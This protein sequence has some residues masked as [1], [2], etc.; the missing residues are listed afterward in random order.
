MK[1]ALSQREISKM[2]SKRKTSITTIIMIVFLLLALSADVPK[3]SATTTETPWITPAL[4]EPFSTEPPFGNYTGC[5]DETLENALDEIDDCEGDKPLYVLVCADEEERNLIRRLTRL[6]PGHLWRE[7]ATI[8]IERGDEALVANF[9]IDIRILGFEEWITDDNITRMYDS[10]LPCLWNELIE[11]KGHYLNQWYEGEHWSDYVDAII[12]ITYQPTPDYNPQG[13]STSPYLLDQRKA[14]V[15]LRWYLHWVD[16][17]LVQH[18]ISHLYYAPDHPADQSTPCGVMANHYHYHTIIY[19]D[20]YWHVWA[21]MPCVATAYTW[22]DDCTETIQE[23]S[24]RYASKVLTISSFY[25]GTTNPSPGVYEYSYG[26][27]VKISAIRDNCY[28]RF[29]CWVL[30]GSICLYNPLTVTMTWNHDVEAYFIACSGGGGGDWPCP[31]LFVWNGND[32]VDYGVIDIHD[33][34]G[35]DMVREVSIAKQDLAVEDGKAKLQLQEGWLGLNFSESVIDQ[36]KLYAI[37]EDGKLKLCPLTT[38]VHSRLGDVREYVVASDD[39]KAQ[40][41]LLETID[42]TFKV[43]EDSQGF[44]FV[45]E[46]CNKFKV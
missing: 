7:W 12:G 45:I 37:D 46:G 44:I 43:R 22:C 35:E 19:E 13:L 31:T 17:N 15:L 26:T 33:P 11:D 5:G 3:V 21:S 8:Q 18:E 34:S 39:V 40:I 41:F 36:V 27:Q 23:H 16:D 20:R 6:S 28:W 32:Y 30:D 2:P 42:L 38:A 9:G 24:G 10:T 25:G 14:F 4:P 1:Y 29:D